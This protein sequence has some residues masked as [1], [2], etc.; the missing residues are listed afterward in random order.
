MLASLLLFPKSIL[1]NSARLIFQEHLSFFPYQSSAHE[2]SVALHGVQALHLVFNKV[3][4]NLLL[5]TCLLNHISSNILALLPVN[6]ASVLTVTSVSCGHYASI[7]LL[8]FLRR[9][10]A[11]TPASP[12]KL[13]SFAP[14]FSNPIQCLGSSPSLTCSLEFSL[15]ILVRINFFSKIPLCLYLKFETP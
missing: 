9:P 2:P 5:K 12:R 8:W 1:G 6:K 14:G 4:S 7:L 13:P 11:Q 15:T 3:F 10:P